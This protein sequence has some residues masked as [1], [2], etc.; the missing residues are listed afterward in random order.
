MSVE[1]NKST[2]R[3]VFEEVFGKGDVNLISQFVDRNFVSHDPSMPQE[4]KGHEGFS[5]F[6]TSLRNSFPDMQ[7]KVEDVFGEG[8]RVALRWSCTGTHKGE[9]GSFP[10]SGKRT[11]VT[12]T[13]I[14]R[15]SGGKIV[16]NW[17][18]W[19]ALGLMQQ[20]GAVPELEHAM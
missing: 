3:R 12:G 9:F 5:N 18:H 19:D 16:E 17:S 20:I 14:F 7:M 10:A 15:F 11:K 8:D 1:Q 13:D 2:V 4:I 6:V